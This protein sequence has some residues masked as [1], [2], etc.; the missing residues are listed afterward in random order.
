MQQLLSAEHARFMLSTVAAQD[1]PRTPLRAFHAAAAR[2]LAGVLQ[3]DVLKY[4]DKD[5]G[6]RRGVM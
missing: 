6:L 5:E 3:A 4:K 1:A 2:D